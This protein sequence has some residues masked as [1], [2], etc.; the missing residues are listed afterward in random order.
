[1]APNPIRIP[2]AFIDPVIGDLGGPPESSR[3]IEERRAAFMNAV[4]GEYSGVDFAFYDIRDLVDVQEILNREGNA[5]GYVVV[6][7]NSIMEL[8]RFFMIISINDQD[9]RFIKPNPG[10]LIVPLESQDP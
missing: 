6:S 7:L 4:R 2:E 10:I 3:W 8:F 5:V 1:M 9:I